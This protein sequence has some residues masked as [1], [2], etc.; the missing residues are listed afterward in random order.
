[1]MQANKQTNMSTHHTPHTQIGALQ[2]E[3]DKQ[4]FAFKDL[5]EK[6]RRAQA[7]PKLTTDTAKLR[8][9]VERVDR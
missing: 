8:E 1:M 9:Y 2:G 5:Q 7:A 3:L 6:L 4:A